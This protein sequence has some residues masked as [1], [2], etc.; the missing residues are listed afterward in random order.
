MCN[1]IAPAIPDFT[2]TPDTDGVVDDDGYAIVEIQAAGHHSGAPLEFPNLE[3]LPATGRRF[4]L[5][6]GHLKVKVTDGKIQEIVGLKSNP[7]PL[8]LYEELRG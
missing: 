5:P 2:W 4:H 3:P 8:A 7:G 1:R 6:G